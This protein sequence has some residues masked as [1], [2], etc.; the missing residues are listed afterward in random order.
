MAP[1]AY[2]KKKDPKYEL[3]RKAGAE[4]VAKNLAKKE[5]EKARKKRKDRSKEQATVVQVEDDSAFQLFF[6]IAI[7][8]LTALVEALDFDVLLGMLFL[9]FTKVMHYLSEELD[10]VDLDP[11]TWAQRIGEWYSN[12]CKT[13]PEG[14]ISFVAG[15][16]VFFVILIL[17]W[18]DLSKWWAERAIRAAGYEQGA[19]ESD[20]GPTDEALESLFTSIDEDGSG[21]IDRQEMEGAIE[22]MFGDVDDDVID[23]MMASTDKDGDNLIS[24]EE[25]FAIMRAGPRRSARCRR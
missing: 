22:K 11:A 24:R 3:A 10:N 18:A 23:E 12:L 19:D 25:F 13:N 14:F 16:F 20:S 1:E 21:E 15:F 17:F 4:Q 9:P 2:G 8:V 5:R 7:G 6:L